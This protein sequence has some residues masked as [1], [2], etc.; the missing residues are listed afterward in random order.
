MGFLLRKLRAFAD[1][2][3]PAHLRNARHGE[4]LA[5][6]YLK[7]R[8]YQIVAVN[9]RARNSRGEVD[10]F[11]YHDDLLICIEVKTRKSADFGRPEEFVGREKRG[12]LIRAAE[13]YARRVGWNPLLIRYDIVSVTLEPVVKIEL[14][15]GA[16]DG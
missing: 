4:D 14:F 15:Q 13:E 8:G 3:L 16:F 11:A 7:R 12:H 5:Y 1:R 10:L 2:K 6:D 9:Y